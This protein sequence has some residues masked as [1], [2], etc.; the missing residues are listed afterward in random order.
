M[1]FNLKLIVLLLSIVI[2]QGCQSTKIAKFEPSTNQTN[3]AELEVS[4]NLIGLFLHGKV[5]QLEM[6]NGCY[7]KDYDTENV[8]GHVVSEHKDNASNN[9]LIPSG[10]KLLFQ[11]GTTEPSWNCHTHFSFTPLQGEKYK[12]HYEMVFAG[13]EV[14]ITNN[15]SKVKDVEYISARSGYSK[16][17]RECAK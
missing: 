2:L 5:T 8:I 11:F 13:C 1:E 4:A 10:N 7:D 3:K 12:I 15:G 17:W 14:S 6:F 16:K 9:I